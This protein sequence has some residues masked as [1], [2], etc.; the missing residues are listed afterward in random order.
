M[1]AVA[2]APRRADGGRRDQLWRWARQRW[3][4]EVIEGASPPGPFN[5]SAAINDAARRAGSWDIAAIIDADTVLEPARVL[6]GLELART[7]RAVLPFTHYCLVG[8]R[9]TDQLMRAEQLPATAER[10]TIRANRWSGCVIVPRELFDA[11]GGFD[12]RFVGWGGEDIGFAA[13]LL[14]RGKVARLPGNL[15]HLWHPHSV[16]RRH[17]TPEYAVNAALERRYVAALELEGVDGVTLFD[18]PA[19]HRSRA[20]IV[21]LERAEARGLNVPDW[22]QWW[23]GMSELLERRPIDA[24][25][26]PSSSIALIVHTDGRR[27]YITATIASLEQQITG[28]IGRRIIWDDSGDADYQQWLE[29]SFPSWQVIGQPAR[30]GY[31][32]SMRALWRYIGELDDELIFRTEDD[33]MFERPVDL[34]ELATVLLAHPELTQMTLL[35]GPWYAEELE[36]GGI[37]EA[38]P[39]AFKRI[40]EGGQSWLE[41]RTWWSANPSLF[42]RSLTQLHPWPAVARSEWAYSRRVT[43]D[44]R[45]RMA[46][47]GDGTPWVRHIGE[48]KLGFGH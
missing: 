7:G 3:P 42:R 15:F 14:A 17:R 30:L 24:P 29:R 25:T 22:S 12:E 18:D 8:R 13:A 32:G 38:T 23:P 10:T 9:E 6:E 46:Y 44:R 2:L 28:A 19:Q 37:I 11:V 27:D 20:Q 16:E 41:H 40:D 33:F 39:S 26:R 4:L 21:N 5:R 36:A 48:L 35:R 43:R 47:W 1:R 31:T 34:D 45:A